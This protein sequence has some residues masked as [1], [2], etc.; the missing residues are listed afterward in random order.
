MNHEKA[1][2]RFIFQEK[3]ED[4]KD[5]FKC[6]PFYCDNGTMMVTL[7]IKQR[8]PEKATIITLKESKCGHDNKPYPH[9]TNTKQTTKNNT[10]PRH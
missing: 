4:L 2:I 10:R 6:V 8:C 1:T 7:K 5:F 9:Q 3:L